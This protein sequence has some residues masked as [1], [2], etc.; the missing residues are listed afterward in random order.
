VIFCGFCG[1]P[2]EPELCANCRH[3]PV[4]PYLQRGQEP[5]P[6]ERGPEIRRRLAQAARDLDNPTAERL[7]ER[8]GVSARTV[9]RWQQ[10]TGVRPSN[11]SPSD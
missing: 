5:D 3:D 8:L 10:M 6:V 1:Q 9:R 4:L 7:A 11:A 2:T